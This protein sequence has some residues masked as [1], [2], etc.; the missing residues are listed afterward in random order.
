MDQDSS[1]LNLQTQTSR[2]R[3]SPP[4]SFLGRQSRTSRRK[5]SLVGV[6]GGRDG[7]KS[8]ASFK[9]AALHREKLG[10]SALPSGRTGN[11]GVG[12]QGRTG[13]NQSR[14]YRA[15]PTAGPASMSQVAC[16]SKDRR[17]R[18]PS[19]LL[20]AP[21]R[22]PL[23]GQRLRGKRWRLRPAFALWAPR[24]RGP[25]I[26]DA[27]CPLGGIGAHS[28]IRGPPTLG[29]SLC[30]LVSR[31]HSLVG[32]RS[33]ALGVPITQSPS[34][35]ARPPRQPGGICQFGISVGSV[36]EPGQACR[37]AR[38]LSTYGARSKHASPPRCW[39][40]F[41]RTYLSRCSARGAR[42]WPG[43]PLVGTREANT[44]SASLMGPSCLAG[45][46]RLV[47]CQ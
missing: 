37:L 36:L 4:R 2:F 25:P 31:L 32:N 26:T 6:R 35:A 39:S 34:T 21:Y 7:L 44:A 9:S 24:A 29:S 16:S 28:S 14:A 23:H 11:P 15:T 47:V 22:V 41:A 18:R 3:G 12:R 1:Q 20:C 38:L 42:G 30:P 19:L 45:V 10:R 43:P 17:R 5:G 27:R 13:P 33:M 8:L 40:P 46:A